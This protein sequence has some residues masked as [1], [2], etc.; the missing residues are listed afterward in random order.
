MSPPVDLDAANRKSGLLRYAF[1]LV[2]I[3]ACLHDLLLGIRVAGLFLFGLGVYEGLNERV[4]MMGLFWRIRGYMT[5][6]A[7]LAFGAATVFVSVFFIIEPG[8][9]LGAVTLGR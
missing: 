3:A 9:I 6:P 8:G 4:P 5:G 1:A 7:A 2:F